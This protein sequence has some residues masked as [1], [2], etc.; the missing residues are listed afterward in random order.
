LL[1]DVGAQRVAELA[2]GAVPVRL[3]RARVTQVGETYSW[4]HKKK[5]GERRMKR[6]VT[7]YTPSESYLS[8][9]PMSTSTMRKKRTY[10]ESRCERRSR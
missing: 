1:G 10:S 2:D 7:M 5:H 3:E 9:R 4:P 8:T 6:V